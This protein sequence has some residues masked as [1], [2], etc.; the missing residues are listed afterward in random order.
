M[1]DQLHAGVAIFSRSL[2]AEAK[3]SVSSSKW[4]FSAWVVSPFVFE[5]PSCPAVQQ[6][7]TGT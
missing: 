7:I 1:L 3:A 4:P 5:Q 2:D 6:S